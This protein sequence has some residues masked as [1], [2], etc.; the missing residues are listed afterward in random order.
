MRYIN[1]HLI[2][3]DLI[4]GSAKFWPAAETMPKKCGRR[5]CRQILE[6]RSA[7][8]KIPLKFGWVGPYQNCI[9]WLSFTCP[10]LLLQSLLNACS[11]LRNSM[12]SSQTSQL[13][14]FIVFVSCVTIRS[15]FS[16]CNINVD[17]TITTVMC[18]IYITQII[19]SYCRTVCYVCYKVVQDNLNF[20][21]KCSS[22]L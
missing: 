16:D 18:V 5:K 13:R 15:C 21:Q 12:A 7:T 2:W 6:S 3:F 8:E 20:S 14:N 19:C 4:S 9:K 22:Q 1:P 11:A 17:C 10:H